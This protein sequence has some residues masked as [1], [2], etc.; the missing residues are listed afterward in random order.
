[1]PYKQQSDILTVYQSQFFTNLHNLLGIIWK[2]MIIK[3][4]NAMPALLKFLVL[5]ALFLWQVIQMH[6]QVSAR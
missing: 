5:L 4:M 1:M 3:G 6:S 2:A